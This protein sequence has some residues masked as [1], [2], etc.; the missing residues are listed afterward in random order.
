[1][2]VPFYVALAAFFLGAAA[3]A[4]ALYVYCAVAGPDVV[5]EGG[6]G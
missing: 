2:R 3:G 5:I 6:A 1:M 4:Y